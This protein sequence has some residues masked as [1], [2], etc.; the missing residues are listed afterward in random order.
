MRGDLFYFMRKDSVDLL[1]YLP[2]FLVKDPTFKASEDTLSWEHEQYRLKLVDMARQFFLET[3]TWGLEDWERFLGITPDEGQSFEL[4]KAVARQK[5]RG[6]DTMTVENTLKLMRNFMDSG[7]PG[8]VELGDNEIQLIL[9]NG[10]Y[11]FKELFQALFDYLPA[12]LEFSLK[13]YN[14]YENELFVGMPAVSVVQDTIDYADFETPTNELFLAEKIVDAT[15][16]VIEYDS[17]DYANLD[18]R[19][20]V[21]TWLQDNSY[22]EIAA[23]IPADSED[24]QWEAWLYWYWK[25]YNRNPV[26]KPY[27]PNYD[28]DDDDGEFDPD[29]PEW[30]EP[31]PFGRDFLRLYWQ[32]PDRRVR[33]M[34]LKNPRKNVTGAEINAV[35]NY[36]V[37]NKALLNSNGYTPTKIRKALYITQKKINLLGGHPPRDDNG[38]FPPPKPPKPKGDNQ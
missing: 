32:F 16:N 30:Q 21:T 31:F 2:P 13:F 37:Q 26:V 7:E 23:D 27:N 12:Q 38:K 22:L 11:H 28:D 10:V 17:S 8:V 14:H 9:E 36:A 35:G 5:L 18:N 29:D 19:L 33:Y 6:A 3:C 34:T 1:R 20:V 15:K 24:W 4:R 25:K